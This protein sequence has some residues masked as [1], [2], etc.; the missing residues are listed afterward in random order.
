MKTQ[1]IDDIVCSV[2]VDE[3]EVDELAPNAI[4]KDPA[5][6][7]K[8][9]IRRAKYMKKLKADAEASIVCKKFMDENPNVHV[10]YL[11]EHLQSSVISTTSCC[12]Q[13]GISPGVFLRL[14]KKHNLEPAY[15]IK[16]SQETPFGKKNFFNKKVSFLA[17]KNFY[18]PKQLEFIP[19]EEIKKAQLQAAVSLKYPNGKGKPWIWT[20]RGFHSENGKLKAR[21]NNLDKHKIRY[22]YE[23]NSDKYFVNLM[24]YTDKLLTRKEV[25]KLNFKYGRFEAFL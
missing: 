19:K 13:L 4:K 17:V 3:S 15:S 22:R 11:I 12:K 25:D 14:R 1:E 10:G 5:L 2:E 6:L 16:K 24:G 21:T 20:E 8:I 23:P 7:K 9:S 18:N